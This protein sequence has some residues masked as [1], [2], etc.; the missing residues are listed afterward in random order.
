[1]VGIKKSESSASFTHG[2]YQ[3]LNCRTLLSARLA[4]NCVYCG[5]RILYIGEPGHIRQTSKPSI[6]E[7]EYSTLAIRVYLSGPTEIKQPVKR[8]TTKHAAYTDG[9][10]EEARHVYTDLITIYAGALNTGL[11]SVDNNE[12][13]LQIN[14]TGKML[15]TLNTFT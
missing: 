9:M 14:I 12:H 11:S 10:A 3:C 1:M 5:L 13:H 8:N 15:D 7:Y 6:F 2:K 4:T